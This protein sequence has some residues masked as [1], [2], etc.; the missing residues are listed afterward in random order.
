MFRSAT[1]S[2][3][4]S[5]PPSKRYTDGMVIA[6]KARL[7]VLRNLAESIDGRSC[8]QIENNGP[9]TTTGRNTM[10]KIRSAEYLVAVAIITS[11]TVMQIRE[12]MQPPQAPSAQPNAAQL[13]CAAT[14]GGVLL[15]ACEATHEKV[16]ANR[17]RV[18]QHLRD[19][20]NKLWV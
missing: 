13:S 15:T 20:S 1:C 11:A 19:A 12:H 6:F 16:P 14:P 18:T 10:K 2:G 17:N 4:L 9:T 8:R 3:G 5:G 7:D